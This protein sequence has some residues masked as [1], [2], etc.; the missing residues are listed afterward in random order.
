[1]SPSENEFYH[2]CFG[3]GRYEDA[4][5]DH[6]DL[7]QTVHGNKRKE[8]RNERNERVSN[9]KRGPRVNTK[10]NRIYVGL[11]TQQKGSN[12]RAFTTKPSKAEKTQ[13]LILNG[14]LAGAQLLEE[15]GK[16]LVQNLANVKHNL[17]N[18]KEKFE[19]QERF[20]A[21]LLEMELDRIPLEWRERALWI[22]HYKA[23]RAPRDVDLKIKRLAIIIIMPKY[24]PRM[25]TK[26]WII[27]LQFAEVVQ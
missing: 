4:H 20:H 1:M 2:G 11:A 14:F 6:N 7:F 22:Y 24:I 17:D 13:N 27:P 12:D 21:R 3:F 19:R 25:N 8:G 23:Y 26:S 5:D 18:L 10:A 15:T 9:S 16:N